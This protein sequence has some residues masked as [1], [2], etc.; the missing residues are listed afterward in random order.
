M[1]VLL[2]TFGSRGDVEP[3]AGLAAA[4]RARGAEV[5]VCA[6][7]DAGV[8]DQMARAG[9]ELAPAF[10]A[11]RDFLHEV[12]TGPPMDLTT[13]ARGVMNGQYEAIAAAAAGCDLVLATGLFPSMAAAQCVAE[14][15]GV[16]YVAA[17]YCPIYLPSAK[18]RPPGFPGFPV[19]EDVT[20]NLALWERDIGVRNALFG[21]ALN[22]LRGRIGL[23]ALENVRDHVMTTQL[24]LAADP[25]LGPWEGPGPFEVIQTGAW[26]LPDD[27]PLPPALLAFLEAGEAPVYAGFGSMPM[28]AARDAGRAAIEAARAHGRRIVLSRG[29]A[30]FA[31][32]DD[33]DDAFAVGEVNQQ[34]LFPRM[35]AV[36]HHGGAGTT[37]TAARAGAPQVIVPQVADQ[38]YWGGRVE[39]LG[40]GVA[41]DGA[42]PTAESL[43]AALGAALR[44]EVAERARAV[45][46]TIRGDGAVVGAEM[47]LNPA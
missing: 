17:N 16:R 30:E 28:A 7:A 19:P 13:R 18:V 46:P 27:R 5:V 22:D 37:H 32:I 31:L 23:P 34:A 9:A 6:P 8:A 29:W 12:L 45:A 21:A 1:R 43:T 41:H 39:A 10:M 42:T 15:M 14:A 40:I 33:R 26:I 36:I 35:A 11:V 47:L 20:D 2:S 3:L 25:V 4:L 38:P 44:P 24:V